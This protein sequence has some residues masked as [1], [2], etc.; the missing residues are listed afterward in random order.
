MQLRPRMIRAE[1]F[2]LGLPDRC[3]IQLRVKLLLLFL[4]GIQKL[5]FQSHG[6]TITLNQIVDRLSNQSYGITI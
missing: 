6:E 3:R 2:M 4:S 1:Y 5:L